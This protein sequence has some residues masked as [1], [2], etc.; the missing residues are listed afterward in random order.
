MWKR[1]DVC[2]LDLYEQSVK[3]YTKWLVVSQHT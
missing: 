1:F 2:D 3:Q